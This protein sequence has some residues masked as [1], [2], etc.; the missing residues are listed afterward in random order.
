MHISSGVSLDKIFSMDLTSGSGTDVLRRRVRRGWKW[1]GEIVLVESSVVMVEWVCAVLVAIRL[2]SLLS[3]ASS[4]LIL[5]LVLLEPLVSL[6][7]VPF[8]VPRLVSFSAAV[9]DSTVGSLIFWI[10]SKSLSSE[11]SSGISIS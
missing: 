1:L 11:Q 9:I 3:A 2:S 6:F 8:G 4:L 10:A 5:G 7:D